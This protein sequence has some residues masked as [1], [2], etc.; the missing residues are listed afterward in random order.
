MRPIEVT[1]WA[2]LNRAQDCNAKVLEFTRT[3]PSPNPACPTCDYDMTVITIAP[4]FLRE[5]CEDISYA[6]EKCGTQIQRRVK[7][8]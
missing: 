8:S 4:A 5:G 2:A 6:C 1:L 7:S 3:S